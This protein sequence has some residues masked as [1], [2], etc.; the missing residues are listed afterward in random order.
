MSKKITPTPEGEAWNP[1]ENYSPVIMKC[2]S[3]ET[4]D[5]LIFSETE[6]KLVCSKC[7]NYLEGND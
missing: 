3:C 1:N 5:Y 7:F 4:F 6:K 2:G